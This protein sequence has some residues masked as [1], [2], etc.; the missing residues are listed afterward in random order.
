[1]SVYVCRIIAGAGH[2]SVHKRSVCVQ[3]EGLSVLARRLQAAVCMHS[4][5][6][7][8]DNCCC[9]HT[10]TSCQRGS[11]WDAGRQLMVLNKCIWC[12]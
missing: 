6:I 7:G 8:C 9:C 1:M 3:Q 5:P 12:S 10:V 2:G 11:G 4:C